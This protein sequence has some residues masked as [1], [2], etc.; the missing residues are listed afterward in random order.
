MNKIITAGS[1]LALVIVGSVTSFFLQGGSSP[2][3]P[4]TP[5]NIA[6]NPS[7]PVYQS[8]G[9]T[10]Q[11]VIASEVRQGTG[12]MLERTMTIQ[13]GLLAKA[14]Q[15]TIL[16]NVHYKDAGCVSTVIATS[17]LPAGSNID[18]LKGQTLTFVG[19]MGEY[20]GKPQFLA[21]SIK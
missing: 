9:K 1:I 21:Q 7:G 6:F 12:G 11:E 8:S 2:H 14:G 18:S 17:S 16:N 19:R 5:A 13:G 3:H 4:G 15:L 20:K 10:A